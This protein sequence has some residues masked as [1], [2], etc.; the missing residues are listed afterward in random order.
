MIKINSMSLEEKYL[1]KIVQEEIF[2]NIFR[3]GFDEES[4]G[5]ILDFNEDFILLE[6]YKEDSSH[7]GVAILLRED[8]TRIRWEGN[9]ISGIQKFIYR[10]IENYKSKINLESIKTILET[11]NSH[12]GYVTITKENL[13]DTVFIGEIVEIDDNSMLMNEYGTKIS[14]D[15]KKLLLSIEDITLMEAG[16]SYERRIISIIKNKK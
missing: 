10:P 4:F 3:D 11:L 7:D 9:E 5:F 1:N 2:V 6:Y 14:Q 15:R 16:G 13:A 12:F 8:V